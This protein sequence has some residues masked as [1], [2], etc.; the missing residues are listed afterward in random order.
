MVV[1]KSGSRLEPRTVTRRAGTIILGFE[2]GHFES[3][4]EEA[5]DLGA[6]RGLPPSAR[7]MSGRQGGP[8]GGA[9]S[10]GEIAACARIGL[11]DPNAAQLADAPASDA[12]AA[13][14]A[15]AP[16]AERVQG[17]EAA[18]APDL[19]PLLADIRAVNTGLRE[20]DALMAEMQEDC[21]GY[22]TAR[23][24]CPRGYV[25]SRRHTAACQDAV[26]RSLGHLP[27]LHEQYSAL[28]NTA[29]RSGLVPGEV[30]QALGRAGLD[31]LRGRLDDIRARLDS[32]SE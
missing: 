15:S 12:V 28:W 5:V 7:G 11:P 1:L 23:A 17:F 30:R 25:G 14:D 21:S 2:D 9:R 29:R 8:G 19:G 31:D 22:T 16:A 24:G 18:A 13:G 4:S 27:T 6:S 26:R 20:L 10:L 3:Y 32:L